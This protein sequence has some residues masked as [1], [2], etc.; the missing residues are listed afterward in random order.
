MSS[1]RSRTKKS[2][3]KRRKSYLQH[4]EA[5]LNNLLEAFET[6]LSISPILPNKSLSKL[7]YQ[8]EEKDTENESPKFSLS[9]SLQ[10]DE[11]P[12]IQEIQHEDIYDN[13]T[14]PNHNNIQSPQNNTNII[15]HN[16]PINSNINN[17]QS[18]QKEDN[19][20]N[21][22]EESD[23]N[24]SKQLNTVN[25]VNNNTINIMN[26][27]HQF[28]PQQLQQQQPIHNA[29]N[30]IPNTPIPQLSQTMQFI[31]PQNQIHNQ[32]IQHQQFSQSYDISMQHNIYQPMQHIQSHHMNTQSQQQQQQYMQNINNINN[33][34]HFQPQKL[35]FPSNSS[36]LNL[37]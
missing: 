23:C 18:P 21:I 14:E 27:S 32:S 5:S 35:V 10:T 26:E 13:N 2:K 30:T 12:R 9:I 36:S 4:Y 3:S 22:E 28:I 34:S 17:I 19:I 16:E 37:S 20:N 24:E 31:H 25:N 11:I 15:T 1:N 8:S 29:P 7:P 6:N 33:I